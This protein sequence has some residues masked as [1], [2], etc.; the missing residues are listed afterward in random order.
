MKLSVV[1]PARNEEA[2]VAETIRGVL[3][4]QSAKIPHEVIVVDDG[5]TDS[6]AARVLALAGS[7]SVTLIGNRGRHGFRAAVRVGLKQ[8]TGDA[9]AVMMADA[10]DDPEDLVR[11]YRKLENGFECVFGSRFIRG[12]KIVDYPVHKLI[13]NRLANAIPLAWRVLGGQMLLVGVKPAAR[14]AQ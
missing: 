13:V 1:I 2:C 3:S 5:S 10:P 12:R 6:T 11:Y 7:D 4:S 9:A 14:K 8:S